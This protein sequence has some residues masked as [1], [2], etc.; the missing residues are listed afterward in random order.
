LIGMIIASCA[1][2]ICQRVLPTKPG[3]HPKAP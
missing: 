2:W 3:P 1:A